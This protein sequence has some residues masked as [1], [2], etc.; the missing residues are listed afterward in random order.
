MDILYRVLNRFAIYITLTLIER[1]KRER[2][3]EDETKS[4]VE[5]NDAKIAYLLFVH[6]CVCV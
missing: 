5:V 3:L 1:E 2:S 6:E 4:V